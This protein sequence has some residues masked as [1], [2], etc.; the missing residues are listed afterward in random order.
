MAGYYWVRSGGLPYRRGYRAKLKRQAM[1]A[2]KLATLAGVPSRTVYDFID[3]KG[4]INSDA[5]GRICDVLGVRLLT[6]AQLKA[7]FESMR[8]EQDARE[9]QEQ[10]ATHERLKAENELLRRAMELVA[11]KNEKLFVDIERELSPGRA[12]AADF[13]VWPFELVERLLRRG[14]KCKTN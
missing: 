11:Q 4:P 14:N 12:S 1:T 2:N 3:G 5:L 13:A 9:L 7:A 10:L 6:D 8:K